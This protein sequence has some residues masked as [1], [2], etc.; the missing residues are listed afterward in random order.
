MFGHLGQQ[1]A[2]LEPAEVQQD[3]NYSLCELAKPRDLLQAAVQIGDALQRVLCSGPEL[4]KPVTPCVDLSRE[5]NRQ[6]A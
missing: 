5:A 4:Q 3:V 2:V 6:E 1:N